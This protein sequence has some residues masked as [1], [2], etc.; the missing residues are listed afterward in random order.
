MDAQSEVFSEADSFVN[1]LASK[2]GVSGEEPT[3]LSEVFEKE[4][5]TSPRKS[6]LPVEASQAS[7]EHADLHDGEDRLSVPKV[8]AITFVAGVL[9][10]CLIVLA[11]SLAILDAKDCTSAADAPTTVGAVAA[12]WCEQDCSRGYAD[13]DCDAR[14]PCTPCAQ[15]SYGAGGLSN[16]SQCGA[17]STDH[18]S[19]AAT[20]CMD[21]PSGRSSAAGH[22]GPCN[23]CQ[24]GQYAS[25]RSSQCVA[26]AAGTADVDSNASTA[27][28]VCAAGFYAEAEHRGSCFAC[29]EGRTAPFGSGTS[30]AACNTCAVGNF[31]SNGSLLC[32]FCP[33]GRADIDANASTECAVCPLDT[34]AGCGATSCDTCAAGKVDSDANA[35]TPCT[36]CDVGKYY[37]GSSCI[38]C[39]AGQADTDQIST[40]P[41][42]GC[43]AGTYAAM[44][45]WH[46]ENCTLN[47]LV[48]HDDDPSTMCIAPGICTQKCPGGYGDDDCDATTPCVIC[49]RGHFKVNSGIGKCEE[50][51]AGAFQDKVG[52]ILCEPCSNSTQSGLECE[53]SKANVFPRL[54]PGYYQKN[55]IDPRDFS[56][57]EKCLLP[58]AC[59]GGE[60]YR[61]TTGAIIE[62]TCA[63]GYTNADAG[64]KD[65]TDMFYRS[66]GVCQPC[67]ESSIH[68]V[69]VAAAVLIVLV[70]MA[71][72][73]DRVLSRIHDIGG[74]L[75]PAM[76]SISFFQ[77]MSMM[78][79]FNWEWPA[80]FDWIRSLVSVIN[81]DFSFTSFQCS[82]EWGTTE[83]MNSILYTFPGVFLLLGV[84]GAAKLLFHEKDEDT[85]SHLLRK[86][87]ECLF[88]GLFVVVSARYLE[89]VASG[90]ACTQDPATG[91]SVLN[92]DVS[93]ECDPDNLIFYEIRTKAL[94]ACLLWLAFL[95]LILYDFLQPQGKYLF[96]FLTAK[97]EDRWYSRISSN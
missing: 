49:D 68:W 23:S 11:T 48:D 50:C 91:K 12:D 76:I 10:G 25:T 85:N 54:I 5:S 16:C 20:P 2:A 87:I 42:V 24:P 79:K 17:G 47:D 31:L 19:D 82:M 73:L 9:A 86:R 67:G 84:Y 93:I 45:V 18:D 55:L 30:R 89:I 32:E 83:K 97:M 92:D 8:L 38:T 77:S 96:S 64:C 27:C 61:P 33:A 21:C 70:G 34:Y 36:G 14:T 51:P 62:D 28:V 26:C 57:V 71:L 52:S 39:A 22:N 7:R 80:T 60:F 1:P 72:V 3:S 66:D 88:V 65:C 44:G 78:L 63:E 95:A 37:S 53:G 35:A 40:T 13:S 75:A 15:G 29:P 6:G 43:P 69:I 74:L 59:K 81:V 4:S 90:L 58:E 46:C 56:S 41:C 94:L